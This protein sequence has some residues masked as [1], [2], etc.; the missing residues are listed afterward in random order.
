MTINIKRTSSFSGQGFTFRGTGG[1]IAVREAATGG[2][3]GGGGGTGDPSDP[4]VLL[5]DGTPLLFTVGAG[6]NASFST[7]WY[8]GPR[9]GKYA[10]FTAPVVPVGSVLRLRLGPQVDFTGPW[11]QFMWLFDGATYAGSV[12]FIYPDVDNASLGTQYTFDV[13]GFYY[14]AGTL[15]PSAQYVIEVQSDPGDI[16]LIADVISVS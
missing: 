7:G 4:Y 12:S 16:K 5:T 8:G 15:T 3:G 13:V 1:G 6:D 9:N 11:D 10:V 2:S 14:N